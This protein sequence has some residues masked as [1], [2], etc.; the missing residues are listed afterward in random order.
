MSYLLVR[1][2]ELTFGQKF[3]GSTLIFIIQKP[4]QNVLAVFVLWIKFQ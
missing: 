1:V 3:I 2:S 4:L